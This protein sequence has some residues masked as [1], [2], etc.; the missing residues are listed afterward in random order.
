MTVSTVN[1]SYA[2]VT[3]PSKP[4]HMCLRVAANGLIIEHR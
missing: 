3:W 1:H 2:V 4:S